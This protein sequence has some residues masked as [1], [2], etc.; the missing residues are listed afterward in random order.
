ML[1]CTYPLLTLSHPHTLTQLAVDG[2]RVVVR[3]PEGGALPVQ[4]ITLGAEAPAVTSSR[5]IGCL[6]QLEINILHVDL[7]AALTSS[8]LGYEVTYEGVA[9]GCGTGGPCVDVE[10]PA[11]SSCVGGW[12][13]YSCECDTD[14]SYRVV[15][16]A[17]VNPCDPTPCLNEGVCSVSPL[18][19][20]AP[21]HCTCVGG[22]S[23]VK[24]EGVSSG[25]CET[26]FYG[27]PL[28]CQRCKC[29]PGGVVEGVCDGVRG[30]CLCKVS[31]SGELLHHCE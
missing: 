24:C 22:Y 25:A 1:V 17:C 6:R 21:F 23:G 9:S 15:G 4:T 13:N 10:C 16:G 7:R 2:G 20:F 14:N 30:S 18:T 11:H 28:Q 5:F 29:D 27:P 3:S 19:N 12:R 26:G 31:M 8:M